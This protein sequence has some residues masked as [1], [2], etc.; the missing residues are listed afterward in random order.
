MAFSNQGK[1]PEG[2]APDPK[3][4]ADN[5]LVAAL[6]YIWILFLIPLLAKRD[7]KFCQFHA[8]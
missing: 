1:G 3:D 8:K 6:S 2:A 4:V 5:K 7:S